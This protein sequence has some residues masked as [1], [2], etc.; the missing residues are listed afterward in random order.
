MTLCGWGLVAG[1]L[2]G[3]VFSG[4][5]C[6][7]QSAPSSIEVRPVPKEVPENKG[8]YIESDEIFKTAG[9]RTGQ[10]TD[11]YRLGK[12]DVISLSILGFPEGLGYSTG[13]TQIT[14]EQATASKTG[15]INEIMIGPDG[16]AAVPYVGNVQ[17]AGLTLDEAN[18]KIQRA[19]SRYIKIP[20]MSVAV[21][22][23]G[24]RRVYVMGEVKEPGIQKMDIDSLNAYAAIVSAGGFSKRGRSTKVQIIRVVDGTMYYRRLNMKDYV[25]KHDLTQNVTVQDGDIVYVPRTNAI[26]WDEDILPYFQVWT[27]YKAIIK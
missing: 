20:S 22:S 7:A 24:P 16:Y 25:V 1:L 10:L 14:A 8:A 9:L 2:L 23:Y 27:Y 17:L 5:V 15:N 3:N 26:F 18:D 19:L 11:N 6:T 12:Y 4:T 21:K 13:Y